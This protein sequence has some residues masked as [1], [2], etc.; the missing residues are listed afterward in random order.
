MSDVGE[1]EKLFVFMYFSDGDIQMFLD[2]ED[3]VSI[4]EP[5]K[6]DTAYR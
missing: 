6:E 1:L 2:M 3:H 4:C 5:V